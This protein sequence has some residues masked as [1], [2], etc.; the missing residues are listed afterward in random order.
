MHQVGLKDAAASRNFSFLAFNGKAVGVTQ[1]LRSTAP[2]SK[3][4]RYKEAFF[5]AQTMFFYL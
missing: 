1:I 5:F 2:A 3:A 4:A